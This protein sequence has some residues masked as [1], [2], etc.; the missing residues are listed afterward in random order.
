MNCDEIAAIDS[1]IPE[2]Q[3]IAVD[4]TV[5]TLLRLS[6]GGGNPVANHETII[7]SKEFSNAMNRL[8][9]AAGLRV[10]L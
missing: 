7:Y 9:I 5:A 6:K 4:K 8:T 10:A 2:A 1:F 3:R